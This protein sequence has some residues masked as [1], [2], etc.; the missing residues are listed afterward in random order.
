[1]EA[2]DGRAR[3]APPSANV[4]GTPEARGPAP[5]PGV[6]AGARL[7]PGERVKSRAEFG[8]LRLEGKRGGDGP[9]R[10]LAGANGLAWMRLGVAIPRRFGPAVR[11][12]RLRRLYQEAF[13]L[14]KAQGTLPPGVD[15]VLSPAPGGGDPSLEQVRAALVRLACALARRLEGRAGSPPGSTGRRPPP[16]DPAARS[17]PAPGAPPAGGPL[18][19]GVAP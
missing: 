2:A 11:R 16:S 17:H 8:R 14:E 6:R 4:A 12:N 13:R 18:P 7:G 10:G 15:L 5:S 3:R 1:M 9:L 19:P